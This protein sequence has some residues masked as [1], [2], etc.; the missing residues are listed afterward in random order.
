MDRNTS[1][2]NKIVDVESKYLTGSPYK[3]VNVRLT[4]EQALIYSRMRK[5]VINPITGEYHRSDNRY[6][7]ERQRNVI[8]GL[9]KEL[10]SMSFT[11]M[12]NLVGRLKKCVKTS[13]ASVN[14]FID[15]MSNYMDYKEYTV[16]TF[17]VPLEGKYTTNP[18]NYQITPW[19]NEEIAREWQKI[20]MA[21]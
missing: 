20:V 3:S 2:S 17:K 8:T 9:I 15:M 19:D 5:N 12:C 1:G 10:Q 14:E 7:D 11:E 16:E 13:V 6:R 4:G 18:S 21:K